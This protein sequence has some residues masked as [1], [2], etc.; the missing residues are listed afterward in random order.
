MFLSKQCH[1]EANSKYHITSHVIILVFI[2]ILNDKGFILK[3]TSEILQR[4][5]KRMNFIFY[6][7]GISKVLSV[8]LIQT[9]KGA[10]PDLPSH[11]LYREG[12]LVNGGL[13][14]SSSLA[15]IV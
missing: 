13:T 6:F 14:S 15:L 10:E 3:C 5:H 7:S 9:N 4:C 11:P 12:T 2:V 1:V 8:T